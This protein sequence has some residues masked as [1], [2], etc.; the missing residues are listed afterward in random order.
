MH[1]IRSEVLGGC[2]ALCCSACAGNKTALC[3]CLGQL[4]HKT[5]PRLPSQI[6]QRGQL[7]RP[8][9]GRS[10][11][12]RLD[13]NR[14]LCAESSLNLLKRR[15][16]SSSSA[17]NQPWPATKFCCRFCQRRRLPMRRQIKYNHPC[18]KPFLRRRF[19]IPALKYSCS[20]FFAAPA[21]WFRR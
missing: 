7:R 13:H 14:S 11:C 20:L 18:R 15:P 5:L 19:H 4:K 1:T 17:L 2:K 12:A 6:L 3:G 21:G 10:W 9:P 8:L 16:L